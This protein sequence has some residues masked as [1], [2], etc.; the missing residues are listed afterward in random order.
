VVKSKKKKVSVFGSMYSDKLVSK[1]KKIK[2]PII[3]NI[4]K[5]KVVKSI[6]P[7]EVKKS[8]KIINSIP[9]E[10]HIIEKKSSLFEGKEKY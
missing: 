2:R 8:I 4:G 1:S 7:K 6:T 3:T 10:I 9:S 5:K